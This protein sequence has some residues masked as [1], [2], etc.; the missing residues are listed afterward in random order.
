MMKDWTKKKNLV[1]HKDNTRVVLAVVV[2]VVTVLLLV[3][4]CL[5]PSTLVVA[6]SASFRL[7]QR[8]QETNSHRE[9]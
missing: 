7:H 3:V 1:S 6:I 9:P 2:P 5:S 4:V 8:I